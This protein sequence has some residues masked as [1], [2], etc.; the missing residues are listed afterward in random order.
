MTRGGFAR[1]DL[2]ATLVL[3]FGLGVFAIIAPSVG[4]AREAQRAARCLMNQHELFMVTSQ[5]AADRR[6][7]LPM[8]P[9]YDRRRSASQNLGS[10]PLHE[11]LA[12]SREWVSSALERQLGVR[13]RELPSDWLPQATHWHLPL[14]DYADPERILEWSVCP[15]HP[16][17]RGRAP[18]RRDDSEHPRPPM[19]STRATDTRGQTCLE[20]R[21]TYEMVPT[22]YGRNTSGFRD[23]PMMEQGKGLYEYRV[24]TYGAFTP[25]AAVEPL[26]GSS[27]KALFFEAMDR[28]TGGPPLPYSHPDARPYITFMDGSTRRTST[29]DASHSMRQAADYGG[30]Y[31]YW[32]ETSERSGPFGGTRVSQEHA[33]PA[34]YRWTYGAGRG[35][36]IGDRGRELPPGDDNRSGDFT[37]LRVG[38]ETE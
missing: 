12:Y 6:G 19:E 18:E 24:P 28:H 16:E 31:F 23:P 34:L 11:S 17:I 7:Q 1:A 3:G 5:Y 10:I 21:T 37:V 33:L 36:D 29:A 38:S 13:P 35:S 27:H 8:V 20:L 9:W 15:S 25:M 4:G 32:T 26:T 22:V 2:L 14:M 30:Q